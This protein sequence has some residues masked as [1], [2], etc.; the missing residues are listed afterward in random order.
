[1]NLFNDAL[2]SSDN[3]AL[4]HPVIGQMFNIPALKNTIAVIHL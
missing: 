2:S 4:K 1:M 3:T